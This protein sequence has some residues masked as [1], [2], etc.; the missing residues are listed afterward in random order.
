MWCELAE[1]RQKLNFLPI[2]IRANKMRKNK[3]VLCQ[4]QKNQK[5]KGS[6]IES[7]NKKAVTNH[8]MKKRKYNYKK[9][10]IV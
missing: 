9:N 3:S 4:N 2:K 10:S 8:S 7:K 1:I 5:K 6:Y